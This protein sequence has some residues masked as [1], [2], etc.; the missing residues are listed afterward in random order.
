MAFLLSSMI[1]LN[2]ADISTIVNSAQGMQKHP[3][4]A[5]A[6]TK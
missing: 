6:L 5:G 2:I 4:I 1:F 3:Q